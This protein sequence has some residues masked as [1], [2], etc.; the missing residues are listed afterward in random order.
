MAQEPEAKR[1]RTNDVD[2][3]PE[4]IHAEMAA[5]RASLAGK[6]EALEEK[7]TRKVDHV[8]AKV[9]H[10]KD[11]IRRA[12]EKVKLTFDLPHQV[13]EHPWPMFGASVVAGLIIG[14][15]TRDSDVAA[16]R[17]EDNDFQLEF[18]RRVKKLAAQTEDAPRPPAQP[19]LF[20]EEFR[21]LRQAAVG[22]MM[23]LVRDGL[24]QTFPG[25]APQTDRAVDGITRK[26]GGEPIRN[27]FGTPPE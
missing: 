26:L 9:E 17:K 19:G 6:V 13:R 3:S 20:A 23:S 25:I 27:L 7:V 18:G 5:T 12:G 22:A 15:I 8:K 4:A 21:Y 16:D 10:A 2:G 11:S 24:R 1:R 14:S